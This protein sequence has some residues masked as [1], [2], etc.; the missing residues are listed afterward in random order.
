[1]ISIKIIQL[2]V[3]E[4]ELRSERF[5]RV[6]G[7]LGQVFKKEC[8]PVIV[9]LPEL[10]AT[11]FFNFERYIDESESL[12][13]ETYSRLA[14]WAVKGNCYILAGSIV[15]KGEDNFY[16]TALLIGPDGLLAGTYRK[17][18]LYGY[19][20]SQEKVLLT[21][22]EEPVLVKTKYGTWGLSIC[23]DLRFPELFRKMADEGVD[24]IF[25]IAAWPMVRLKHW[26]LLN[27]VRA[28]ENLS[29]MVSCSCAGN[30]KN[31]ALGGNSMVVDPWGEV[32]SRAGDKEELL[33]AELDLE[34]VAAIKADFPALN[35]RRIK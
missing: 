18:H 32:I 1:M 5:A 13:G 11:G 4:N 15:E 27:R 19:Q 7:Y 29:Y 30:H 12:L 3:D 23:Y 35:D 14:P 33:N 2:S 22:G 31:R 6:E 34:R 26:D 28:L 16:N 21:A 17:I 9:V 24:V 25:N 8:R 20:Q 10:W